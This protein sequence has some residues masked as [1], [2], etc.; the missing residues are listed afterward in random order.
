[1]RSA[2][3]HAS[4]LPTSR[5]DRN[6]VIEHGKRASS[7][8]AICP[9]CAAVLVD[10]RWTIA[11]TPNETIRAR[12]PHQR[13]CPACRRAHARHPEGIVTVHG[14]FVA[15]HLSEIESVLTTEAERAAR[16]HPLARII[17]LGRGDGTGL[18]VTTTTG[19]LAQR[20]GHALQLSFGGRVESD[21][22][23]EQRLTRVSWVR[24]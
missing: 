24:T 3:K 23:Y 14:D 16:E 22:S 21:T 4:A 17:G 5:A 11:E 2:K 15:R 18:V 12:S 9:R 8:V 20:L 6:G 7:E 19:R 1:M 13:V 10:R